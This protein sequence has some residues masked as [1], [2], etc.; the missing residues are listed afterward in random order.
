MPPFA[1]REVL[2]VT[3]LTGLVLLCLSGRYGYHRDELHFLDA[4][5]HLAWGY[6]DQPPLTPLLAR[7]MSAIAPDS[8]VVLRLPSTL[9][10]AAVVLIARE[11]G[12]VTAGTLHNRE[13][14]DG[15][16]QGALLFVCTGPREP[17]S[18]LWSDFATLG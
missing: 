2:G 14:I 6:P 5:K 8:L 9:M 1:R 16:E 10:S 3:A 11:L 15:D 7:A 18:R 13:G 12:V 4:G 17:W